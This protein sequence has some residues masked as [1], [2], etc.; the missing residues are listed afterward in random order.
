MIELADE[1]ASEAFAARIASLAV[2][3]DVIGLAGPLGI[4]KT[5]FARAF[6]RSLTATD[7]TVP[8]PTYT[9]MQFY[10]RGPVPIYHYDLYRIE[11]DEEIDELGFDQALADGITLIEWPE[12]VPRLGGAN[13][14]DLIFQEGDSAAPG[15]RRVAMM[16]GAA[17]RPRLE[18]VFAVLGGAGDV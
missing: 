12:R 13:R 8:S 18:G 16:A 17:W 4:G 3:G 15:H 6:I 2:V 10:D 11:A 5:V 14:L 7:E 9:L 1:P